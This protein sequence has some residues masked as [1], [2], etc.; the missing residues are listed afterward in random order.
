MVK[1]ETKLDTEIGVDGVNFYRD[2]TDAGDTDTITNLTIKNCTID[3]YG[4]SIYG[5]NSTRKIYNTR[6]ENNTIELHANTDNA[7]DAFNAIGLYG[8]SEYFNII[9]NR[10]LGS[11]HSAIGVSM[12]ENGVV[13]YN[14]VYDVLI[15]GEA[16]IEVEYKDSHGSEDIASNGVKVVCNYVY[17]C[18]YGILVTERGDSATS[19]APYNILIDGNTIKDSVVNDIFVVSSFSS[20]TD[21]TSQIKDVIISNNYIDSTAT[22]GGIRV[23]DAKDVKIIGNII[24]NMVNGIKIGRDSNIYPTGNYDIINNNI[25]DV[26]DVGLHIESTK[27]NFRINNNNIINPTGM[28]VFL[29]T[30]TGGDNWE[31]NN[32]FVDGATN[33]Y[34]FQSGRTI[35]L[36]SVLTGNRAIN[37][38]SRGFSMRFDS[39]I[40]KNNISINCTTADNLESTN[41]IISDNLDL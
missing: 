16:G 23:Y 33:G 20:G 5:I 41:G 13:A 39:S 7:N 6:I 36:G 1:N 9:G 31:V 34:Y 24:K 37:C 25:S 40:I 30:I 18:N 38:S 27:A 10:V 21:Y 15:T 8:D 29:S 4:Q 32:N 3:L 2:V 26:T 28:G 11:G 17:N 35:L 12:A 19:Y 14:Y 22:D